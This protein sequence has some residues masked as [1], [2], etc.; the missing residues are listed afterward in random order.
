MKIIAKYIRKTAILAMATVLMTACNA[1]LDVR[2]KGKVIPKTDEEYLSVLNEM[3]Y[4]VETYGNG[5]GPLIPGAAEIADLEAI[6]DNLDA[7]LEDYMGSEK[8]GLPLYEGEQINKR[9]SLW[10]TLYEY[11]RNCN[12][13]LEA[14]QER[15]TE[16]AKNM[17]AACLSI[18]GVCYYNLMRAYCQPYRP[19]SAAD[20]PGLPLVKSFDIEDRPQRS[21]LKETAEYICSLLRESI[22]YGLTEKGYI[23]TQDVTMAYLAKTLFWMQDWNAVIPLCTDL[24]KTYPLSERKD[25]EAMIQELNKTS[26]EIIVKSFTEGSPTNYYYS[27]ARKAASRRPVSKSL[28]DLFGDAPENDIRY[29]VAIGERRMNRKILCGRVRASEICLMQAEAY[30]HTGSESLALESLNILRSKRI[31]NTTPYTSENLPV[32]GKRLITEDAEGKAL[33]LLMS[34][35]F[36]ERRKELFME[37]DRWYELKRNGCPEMFVISNLRKYTTYKYLYTFPIN[38]TDVELGGLE[39]NPG[40]KY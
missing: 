34:A 31:E 8:S 13:I 35:I 20:T 27:N 29:S 3:L 32:P 23:F 36:D 5:S 19:S 1:F 7:N 4:Q 33:T 39:Q 24:L 12:I 9:Q 15:D 11:I 30:A 26:G 37:G 10:K 22:L 28:I 16:L 25:Y 17:S 6:S 14:V 2:P 38:R 40:Y 21:D 18:K